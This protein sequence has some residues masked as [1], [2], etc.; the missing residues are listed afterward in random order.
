LEVA[1]IAEAGRYADGGGLYLIVRPARSGGFARS[2][3][4]R[5][6]GLE[7]KWREAGLG[8]YP[9]V[10]LAAARQRASEV[11]A[12]AA[13]GQDAIAAKKAVKPLAAEMSDPETGANPSAAPSFKACA[14]AYVAAHE[15][16]WTN[17]KHAWQW[18]NTLRKVV[19]PVIGD[20]P[21]SAIDRQAILRVLDPI[22]RKTPE[23]ANRIRGRIE[24]VL[25]W[26][27]ARGL[28][29]GDNPAVWRGNLQFALP[30]PN[31]LRAKQ[32][33]SAL[34]VAELPA[35]VATI[36]EIDQ[37]SAQA[38][39][40]TILTA[41]RTSEVL[42]AKWD[43]FDLSLRVWTVPAERMKARRAHRVPLSDE[44]IEVLASASA[45]RAGDYVFPGARY[46]RPLSNMALL[47]LLRRFGRSDLTT[48]GFRSTFRDWCA[49]STNFPR[50]VAEAALAHV[51]GDKVEAAYL[52][53]EFLEK[54]RALM[55]AWGAFAFDIVR[56]R[57]EVGRI[58][59]GAS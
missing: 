37:M 2:W 26:A 28:R 46:R 30:A 56:A 1:K 18:T 53:T 17:A 22:W 3:L 21:V 5:Y 49:E 36:A 43:E 15:P 16:T 44:A 40:F 58:D 19:Y 59:E 51:V 41:A 11:R 38:L 20:L 9:Q 48:H 39:L 32:S 8:G 34:P 57:P 13:S 47:M 23:T 6:R 50:E 45:V 4:V 25:N 24:L 29:D 52:R 7:G 10:S 14:E 55:S 12:Q 31:K 33:H 35:F 54:R 42:L 27:K